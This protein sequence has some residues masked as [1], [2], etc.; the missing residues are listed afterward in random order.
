MRPLFAAF[1]LLLPLAAQQPPVPQ[2]NADASAPCGYEVPSLAA[3]AEE[4]EKRGDECREQK[5]YPDA[6]DYYRV[7]L[8]KVEDKA[9]RAVLHNK[10]GIAKLQ[11]GEYQN[12]RKSFQRAVKL[13]HKYAEAYNNLG[14]VLFLENNYDKAIQ[15]YL[16][17]LRLREDDASFHSNLATAYFMQKKIPEALKEYRRALQLDPAVFERTSQTG[18]SAQLSAP[19]NRAYYNYLLAR[20]YAQAGDIERSFL[21][22]RKAMEDG[23]KGINN[24]YKDAEF[25]ALR[26]DRR[27]AELMTSRPAA[28]PQ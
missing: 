24:V 25:A 21:H 14:A 17:A 9:P 22:L 5:V 19:E 27:F 16:R 11:V 20:M 18:I 4:L 7:A 8:T 23:Y 12:A 2:Q 15:Q 26:K 1:F 10:I 3:S 6:V 13:N 28:I